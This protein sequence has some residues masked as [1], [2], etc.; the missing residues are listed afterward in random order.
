MGD[1]SGSLLA[2]LDG[3]TRVP[4]LPAAVTDAQGTPK[5]DA[6]VL[7]RIQFLH[8]HLPVVVGAYVLSVTS[9][10]A[11]GGWVCGTS[12]HTI[13]Q[14]PVKVE[15]NFALPTAVEALC[16]EDGVVQVQRGQGG[17]R[18]RGGRAA[19]ELGAVT[20]TGSTLPAGLR[21]AGLRDRGCIC[22][23]QN[24]PGSPFTAPCSWEGPG[25]RGC[26]W[27]DPGGPGCS[28]FW[29]PPA[30]SLPFWLNKALGCDEAH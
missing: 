17:E 26:P 27:A 24:T 11:V 1:K 29:Q 6:G 28:D 18:H 21:P 4:G 25:G 14:I 12:T 19:G 15:L 7:S 8:I 2:Q 9:H 5:Q 10:L 20:D 22:I 13:M 23:P 3:A 16:L 30:S